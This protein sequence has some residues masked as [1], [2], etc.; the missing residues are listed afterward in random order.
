MGLHIAV[1]ADRPEATT[2]FSG[3]VIKTQDNK[4]VI[5]IVKPK[6]WM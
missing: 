6:Q 2:A 4:Y 5:T 3:N 1:S